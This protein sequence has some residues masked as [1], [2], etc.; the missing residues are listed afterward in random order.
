MRI[1]SNVLEPCLPKET[2]PTRTTKAV[3]KNDRFLLRQNF[4]QT[5][6]CAGVKLSEERQRDIART[7]GF[8]F[9]LCLAG[10]RRSDVDDPADRLVQYLDAKKFLTVSVAFCQAFKNRESKFYLLR[11]LIP[12]ADTCEA[13]V[14]IAVLAVRHCVEIEE[15]FQIILLRPV[16]CLVYPRRCIHKGRSVA[17]GEVRHRQAN[18]IEALFR[19]EF[20]IILS[21]IAVAVLFDEFCKGFRL[22]FAAEP[23]LIL[24]MGRLK[25]VGLHP[26]FKNKPVAEIGTPDLFHYCYLLL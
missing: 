1:E 4:T 17:K 13:A 10:A 23:G 14:I 16:K 7:F 11:V 20:E 18:H 2:V 15:Y 3:V 8:F 22:H 5:S 21:D 24:S 26:F 12:V 19:N 6:I 25:Q 9:I